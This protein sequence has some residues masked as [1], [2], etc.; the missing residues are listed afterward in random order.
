V[1]PAANLPDWSHEATVV[2]AKQA[3]SLANMSA[4]YAPETQFHWDY[5]ATHRIEAIPGG[6]TVMHINDRCDIAIFSIYREAKL[7]AGCA[8]GKTNS[9][10]DLF[11]HLHDSKQLGSPE[12]KARRP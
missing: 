1:E 5:S 10:G 3:E 8:L 2:A 6:G 4:P 11:E 12:D 7:S 9:H